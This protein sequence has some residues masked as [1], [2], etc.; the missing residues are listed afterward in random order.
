MKVS[1]KTAISALKIIITAV[2]LIV[3]ARVISTI[4]LSDIRQTLSHL[5]PLFLLLMVLL[6]VLTQALISL[7]WYRLARA[8]DYRGTF[9]QM[10]VLNSYGAFYDSVTP[11]S[12]VGG[13]LRKFVFL[14]SDLGY[15]TQ[16]SV[17]LVAIQKAFSFLALLTLSGAAFIFISGKSDFIP[18]IYLKIAVISLFIILF[19]LVFRL[20]IIPK[21]EEPESVGSRPGI[22]NKISRG[23]ANISRSSS[24]LRD[25]KFE[26]FMQLLLSFI[27]W[28]L[29]PL[30]LYL[31]ISRFGQVPI[32][33][34]FPV[35][36]ISYFMG[37]LPVS[38]GGLGT[39]EGTMT[40]LFSLANLDLALAV[41]ISVI[42]RFLTFWLVLIMSVLVISIYKIFRRKPLQNQ[43]ASINNGDKA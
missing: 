2:I 24:V 26:F 37:M 28:M 18:G 14:K 15:T 34:V 33:L 27:I 11:G 16:E 7:Q 39:F 42:F 31:L 6:Q 1:K 10:V 32:L 36:F 8:L 9:L 17:S 38:P 3:F 29:Y 4:P 22:V 40:G 43:Q 25:D 19:Y 23:F 5:S 13:E 30:K 20:I 41:T 12:K 35:V 21:K